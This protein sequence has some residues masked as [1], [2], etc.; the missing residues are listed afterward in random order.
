MSDPTPTEPLTQTLYGDTAG[1]FAI[2]M[3]PSGQIP[4][5]T[6]GDL[7][8]MG[9]PHDVITSLVASKMNPAGRPTAQKSVAVLLGI[10]QQSVSRYV[11][12][13]GNVRLGADGWRNL[14]KEVRDV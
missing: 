3:M 12:R 10:S 6:I 14:V 5:P 9:T 4:P 11:N 1:E 2:L 8:Y 7:H 13:G